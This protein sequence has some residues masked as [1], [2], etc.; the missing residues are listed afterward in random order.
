MSTTQPP[1]TPNKPLPWGLRIRALRVDAGLTQ[2][3]LAEQIGTT[4]ATI[5]KMERSTSPPKVEWIEKLSRALNVNEAELLFGTS[6][7]KPSRQPTFIPV[8]GMIAAGNW[9]EAIH[10]PDGEIPIVN[11][12]PH[13]FALE[14]S[15]D[16]IDR[17]ARHG[18]FVAIDPTDPA[19][20]DGSI[21][22]VQNVEGET[23]LKRFRRNP[24]RLEPDSTNPD[25]KPI[26]L[27]TEVIT[28]IGRA[29]QVIQMI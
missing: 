1:A 15:G 24:D 8:I 17:V 21:Y 19:L 18:S 16:S 4:K 28:V 10:S 27:G 26:F 29:T 11:A 2:D 12:K 5:S 9:R 23:T 13:M 7:A 25:H 3:A 14:V 22:A 20:N 6:F